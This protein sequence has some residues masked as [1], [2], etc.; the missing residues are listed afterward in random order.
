MHSGETL[1]MEYVC[2]QKNHLRAAEHKSG[3]VLTKGTPY[4]ALKGKLWGVYSE[5]FREIWPHYNKITTYLC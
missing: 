5:G 1:S 3:F 4:L 2:T